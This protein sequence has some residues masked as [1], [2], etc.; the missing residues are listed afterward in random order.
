MSTRFAVSDVQ[1][2]V[3][4]NGVSTGS[5]QSS[6]ALH[7]KFLDEKPPKM[8]YLTVGNAAEA[9]KNVERNQ[10]TVT[11]VVSGNLALYEVS[12]QFCLLCPTVAILYYLVVASQEELQSRPRIAQLLSSLVPV[13]GI[14]APNMNT[15]KGKKKKKVT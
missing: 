10:L 14:M 5:K 2:E 6:P 7:V 1:V 4:G 13:D 12:M 9:S 8:D 3:E 11:S 15:P